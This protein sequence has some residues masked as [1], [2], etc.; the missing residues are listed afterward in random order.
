MGLRLIVGPALSGRLD[1]LAARFGAAASEGAEP[2][3]V[4]PTAADVELLERAVVERQGL[5]LGGLVLGFDDLASIV[6]ERTGGAP[7]PPAGAV[8]SLL[9][10]RL[11]GRA[12]PGALG[13]SARFAGFA[14]AF[15]RFADECA[16]AGVP[17][18][19]LS[20][21]LAGEPE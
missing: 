4:A 9:L 10:R 14:S 3:L 18:A 11:A 6:L 2:L 5:L 20:A 13:R 15:G 1:A 16:A 12:R 17:P 19:A 21:A 7:P 8:R